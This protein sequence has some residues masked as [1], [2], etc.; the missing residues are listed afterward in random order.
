MS[1]LT[2][3]IAAEHSPSR[4]RSFANEVEIIRCCGTDFGPHPTRKP[5]ADDHGKATRDFVAHVAEVTERAV[6]A[7]IA[8]DI[9]ALDDR[10]APHG[11]RPARPLR[12]DAR[13]AT[14]FANDFEWAA[15]IAEGK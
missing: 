5:K 9:R 15:Q 13:L 12:A 10:G 14:D 4:W 8:A 1:D 6:R 11:D 2:D 7:Q 3:K